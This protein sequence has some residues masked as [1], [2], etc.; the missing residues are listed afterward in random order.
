MNEINPADVK[1]LIVDDICDGG[2]TFIKVAEVL[3]NFGTKQI[4]LAVSHGLFSKGGSL[5]LRGHCQ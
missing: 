4:D 5:H 2:M 1:I 3:K